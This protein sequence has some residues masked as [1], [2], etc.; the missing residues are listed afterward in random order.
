MFS[1]EGMFSEDY[2]AAMKA[3][4][5]KIFVLP[6][7]ELPAAVNPD[8][9]EGGLFHGSIETAQ[10]AVGM[11]GPCVGW[12]RWS[13]FTPS[14][15]LAHWGE[16]MLN[17]DAVFVPCAELLRRLKTLRWHIGGGVGLFVRVD[18]PLKGFCSFS[19]DPEA[20][21]PKH[22]TT[23][24]ATTMLL[25]AKSQQLAREWRFIVR[26]GQIVDGCQYA[27]HGQLQRFAKGYPQAA[28]DC[29]LKAANLSW[30]PDPI[31]M[32]DVAQTSK[33]N[34]DPEYK[35]VEVNPFSASDFYDCDIPKV[36]AAATAEAEQA[37]ETGNWE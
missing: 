11:A 24:A 15:V 29:A 22:V 19:L 4:C 23:E 31:Y 37:F 5:E 16:V 30:Q 2:Q 35:V 12:C 6:M 33:S 34:G 26:R 13:N 18:S 36:V 25:L 1:E 14:T 3:A 32:L 17:G 9:I 28:A 7:G 10:L 27:E 21:L 20:K 8:L